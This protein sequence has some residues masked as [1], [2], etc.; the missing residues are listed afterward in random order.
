MKSRTV[1]G[2]HEG[3]AEDENNGVVIEKELETEC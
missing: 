2:I 1:E 3:N